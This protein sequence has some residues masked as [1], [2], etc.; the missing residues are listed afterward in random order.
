MMTRTYAALVGAAVGWFGSS[1]IG[2]RYGFAGRAI[3]M[4]ALMGAGLIVM[5]VVNLRKSQAQVRGES[6]DRSTRP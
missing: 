5:I 1:W 4:A 2:A 6:A 3:S